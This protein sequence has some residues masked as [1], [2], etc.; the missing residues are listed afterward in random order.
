VGDV[1]ER[2]EGIEGCYLAAA[3][4]ADLAAKLCLVRKR[5]KQLDCRGR[6]AEIS[7]VRVA[8]KLRECYKDIIAVPSF[9]SVD[10]PVMPAISSA[11]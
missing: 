8:E 3:D 4:P 7:I 1:A 10:R 5:G 9:M 6:L 11:N 2:I